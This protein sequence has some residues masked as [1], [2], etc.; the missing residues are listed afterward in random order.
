MI[1]EGDAVTEDRS[2]VLNKIETDPAGYTYLSNDVQRTLLKVRL[3]DVPS[4]PGYRSQQLYAMQEVIKAMPP[5]FQQAAM[6]YMVALMDTPYKRE[7]IEALRAAG[8]QESPEQVEKRIQ[9]EVLA[10]LSKAEHD[11]KARELEMKERLTDAQIKKVMADAVQVGVQAAP[12]RRCRAGH[13]SP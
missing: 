13:R 2:V 1:I 3:E 9:Q 10:A 8:S 11:L 12:S 7:I 4:T 5:Q 6:P